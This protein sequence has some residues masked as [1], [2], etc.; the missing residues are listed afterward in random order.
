MNFTIYSKPD[1][2]ACIHAKHLLQSKGFQ[3]Q[4]KIL[5][6][7]Q[8][9]EEGK[10]YYTAQYLKTKI[11]G[12]RTLPQIFEDENLIGNLLSLQ[13]RISELATC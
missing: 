12:A 1:C 8:Q 11:P 13:R 4:E 2:L 5:D 3:Y 9:K 6:V 10:N 7:G